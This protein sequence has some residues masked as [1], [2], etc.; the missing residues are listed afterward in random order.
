MKTLPARPNHASGQPVGDGTNRSTPVGAMRISSE[1][2][3]AGAAELE[4]DHNGV[5][6]RLR[7]TSLG[8]LILTK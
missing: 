3:L 4:I 6:Y 5:V 8:K 2:L 7:K 1:M